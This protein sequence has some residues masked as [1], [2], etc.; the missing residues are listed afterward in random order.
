M[1]WNLN[2]N[3]QVAF[4]FNLG[5]FRAAATRR[6]TV[7]NNTNGG[8]GV[9]VLTAFL[10]N[11]YSP[12]LLD[13]MTSQA[14]LRGLIIFPFPSDATPLEEY[15]PGPGTAGTRGNAALPPQVCGKIRFDGNQP[16]VRAAGFFYMPFPSSDDNDGSGNPT[17]AYLTS[18]QTLAN[19]FRNQTLATQ[20]SGAPPPLPKTT[21]LLA[22]MPHH[23]FVNPNYVVQSSAMG[24][25]STQRRRA[26]PPMLS[27]WPFG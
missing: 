22:T 26:Q 25:W 4:Y 17:A 14:E 13:C 19:E 7:V 2:Q 20:T 3:I 16:L 1:A 9:G 27:N 11:Q 10:W 24:K 12:L 23:S 15:D 21:R 6:F 8:V 5:L 18:L